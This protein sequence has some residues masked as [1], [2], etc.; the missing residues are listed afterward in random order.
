MRV[1]QQPP[2][3]RTME[4]W[5]DFH[6]T[7]SHGRTNC[8]VIIAWMQD[9][10]RAKKEGKQPPAEPVRW[11][12][13]NDQRPNGQIHDEPP[14]PNTQV[15]SGHPSRPKGSP[16]RAVGMIIPAEDYELAPN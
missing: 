15:W 11:A 14:L 4:N 8:R 13:P 16:F 6:G 12:N 5:C 7:S 1:T 10:E 2:A 3:E 9:V